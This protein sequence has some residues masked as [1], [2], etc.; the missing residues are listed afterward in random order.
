MGITQAQLDAEP[1]PD[2]LWLLGLKGTALPL[3]SRLKQQGVPVISK[4]ACASCDTAWFRTEILAYDLWALGCGQEAGM[5]M[6]QGV[7]RI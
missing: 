4:A 1:L 3:L 5:A 2:A 7:V 6:R